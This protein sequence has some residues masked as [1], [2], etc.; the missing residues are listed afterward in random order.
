MEIYNG[1]PIDKHLTAC[2]HFACERSQSGHNGHPEMKTSDGIAGLTGTQ[3]TQGI[4]GHIGTQGKHESGQLNFKLKNNGSLA[5]PGK[6]KINLKSSAADL[7]PGNENV[8]THQGPRCK[9]PENIMMSQ[10]PQ[11]QL[12]H[13]GK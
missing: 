5:V 8:K 7:K 9:P 4:T 13:P 2:I 10:W 12:F 11:L 1:L 6:Q 3:G